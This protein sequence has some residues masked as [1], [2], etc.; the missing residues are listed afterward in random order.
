[1]NMSLA[2]MEKHLKT[3]RLHGMIATLETRIIQA[4]Q[5]AFPFLHIFLLKLPGNL[6]RIL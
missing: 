5:G 2:E 1:M 3:L 4:N 6:N